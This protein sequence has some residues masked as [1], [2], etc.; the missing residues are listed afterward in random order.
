MLLRV[1]KTDMSPFAVFHAKDSHM[2]NT[3]TFHK[4]TIIHEMHCEIIPY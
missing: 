1:T 3:Q 2:Y 4:H